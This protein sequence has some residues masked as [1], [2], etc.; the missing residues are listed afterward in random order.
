MYTD[1]LY[2]HYLYNKNV[3]VYTWS[4]KY[5]TVEILEPILSI[6][7][8]SSCG[9]ALFKRPSFETWAKGTG[10][11]RVGLCPEFDALEERELVKSHGHNSEA[12][13][14]DLTLTARSVGSQP[15]QG[16]PL[17]KAAT[18]GWPGQERG[19]GDRSRTLTSL[20]SACEQAMGCRS[21]GCTSFWHM[22]HS[23][24]AAGLWGQ[25]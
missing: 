9:T 4:Y 2:T 13:G 24:Q 1:F 16:W 14:Q 21:P 22:R 3:H 23:L 5:R 10:V 12:T 20:C 18:K 17:P 19:R 7:S 11:I 15:E 25:Q 6:H 8:N